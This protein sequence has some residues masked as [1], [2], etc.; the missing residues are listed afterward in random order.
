M[1]KTLPLR[2][3]RIGK[4]KLGVMRKAAGGA[5]YPAEVPY[6]VLPEELEKALGPSEGVTKIAVMFPSNDIERVIPHFFEQRAGAA[7]VAKCDGETRT[8]LVA[9]A[10]LTKPCPK[11]SRKPCPHKCQA[12]ARLNVIV[13]GA[14]QFGI[15]QIVC[16]GE[17]RIADLV[18]ELALYQGRLTNTVFQLE[19][20]PIQV[21]VQTDK[22]PM[23]RIGWPVHVRCAIT[24][25]QALAAQGI[26]V[27][28]LPGGQVL[29]PA[30]DPVLALSPA[31]AHQP[32]G[33]S[34]AVPEVGE[35]TVPTTLEDLW[36]LALDASGGHTRQATVFLKTVIKQ[37]FNRTVSSIRDLEQHEVA[38]LIRKLGKGR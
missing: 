19:R 32:E 26:N 27:H 10:E 7:L 38:A 21:Q 5:V 29:P 33:E 2:P 34:E 6:F 18:S 3:P 36:T 11:E 24:T 8:E 4:I 17:Q 13:L 12:K 14:P 15:Y 9:G 23:A 20:V 28:T 1:I 22:G 30:A 37:E 25:E 31:M 16:G 35:A